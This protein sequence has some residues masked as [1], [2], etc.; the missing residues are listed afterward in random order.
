MLNYCMH[1]YI[2]YLQ[3]MYSPLSSGGF[4]WRR[5]AIVTE[6]SVPALS[7]G[8]EDGR[9]AELVLPGSLLTYD[10]VVLSLVLF[11]LRAS[12]NM[13]CYTTDN[14]NCNEIGSVNYTFE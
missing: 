9:T 3:I 5:R 8:A 4:V 6:V 12:S 1:H 7:T 11:L 14:I 10:D 2:S 13:N